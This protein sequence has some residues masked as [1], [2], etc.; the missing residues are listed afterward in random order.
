MTSS[1]NFDI[2]IQGIFEDFSSYFFQV[3]KNDKL[4]NVSKVSELLPDAIG[5]EIS[6]D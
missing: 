1:T 5:S 3:K 2:K 6:G 4:L